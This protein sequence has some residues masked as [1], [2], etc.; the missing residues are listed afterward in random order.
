MPI[1]VPMVSRNII[2]KRVSTT[3][4]IPRVNTP[5][6]LSWRN[7]GE[8]FGGRE[9]MPVGRGA[10]P[11]AKAIAA[12]AMMPTRIA[13]GTF[14][15][16]RIPVRTKQAIASR[17]AGVWRLPISTGTLPLPRMTIPESMRPTKAKK[18]PIPTEKSEF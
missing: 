12:V 6:R 13:A 11:K 1:S 10:I 7:V 15:T 5:A 2:V 16:R 17:T 3:G 9:T 4:N 8:M 14:L 18:S